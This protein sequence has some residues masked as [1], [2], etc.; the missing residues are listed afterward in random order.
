MASAFTH[1]TRSTGLDD[2]PQS[3]NKHGGKGWKREREGR[4]EGARERGREGGN[5]L[6]LGR[7][8]IK[9]AAIAVPNFF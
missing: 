6:T 2:T 7:L 3:L 4:T 1:C 5:G 9:M 8:L